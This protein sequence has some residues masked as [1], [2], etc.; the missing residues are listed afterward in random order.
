M[1]DEW[2]VMKQSAISLLFDLFHEITEMKYVSR[3]N[4]DFRVQVVFG[5]WTRPLKFR[6]IHCTYFVFI[7]LLCV[8]K[9]IQEKV[10]SRLNSGYACYHSAQNIL[11]SRLLFKIVK[12][13]IHEITVYLWLCMGVKFGLSNYGKTGLR[14]SE[15]RVKVKVKVTVSLRLT[16]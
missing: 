15:N 5:T 3:W 2:Q 8:S 10:K 16:H 7:F 9:V 12:I 11:S 14:V 13:R 1:A 4:I 6:I